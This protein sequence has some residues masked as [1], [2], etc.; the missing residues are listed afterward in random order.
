[1]GS[2]EL[3]R[4]P[5]TGLA[6]LVA[7]GE[8]SAQEVVDAHLR[9]IAEVRG[10]VNAVVAVDADRALRAPVRPTR[11]SPRDARGGRCTACRSR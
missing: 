7:S 6:A 1:M 10:A 8:A 4:L 5:A 2:P 3:T 9:R 11:R